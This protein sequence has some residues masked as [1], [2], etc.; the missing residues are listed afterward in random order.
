MDGN[1]T[2]ASQNASRF[3][4]ALQEAERAGR[5]EDLAALFSDDAEVSNLARAEPLRG[6]EG[7]RR[8]WGDYLAAF[9]QVHSAFGAV[10][11]GKDHAVLEWTSEGELPDG[12]AISYRGISVLEWSENR[13][14]CFRTYYDSA[15]LQ[16]RGD[17]QKRPT[18]P[19]D[20]NA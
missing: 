8:F 12:R 14:H 2:A 9:R 10:L 11:E 6:P 3:M 20:L 19:S 15:A 1:T 4:Q 16:A 17:K 18:P 13:I 5:I 7:V